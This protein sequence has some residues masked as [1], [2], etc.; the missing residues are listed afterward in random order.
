[1]IQANNIIK[2][3]GDNT[4]LKG[5]NMDI[6]DARL[7]MLCGRS[8]SGKTTLLNILCGLDLPTEGAIYYS[9]NNI[10][11]LPELDRERKR[12]MEMGFV[13]QSV[14]L[15]PSMSAYEN[16]EF[17]LR[18]TD[19]LED[20]EKRVTQ[21]LTL[22][23]LD[24]RMSHMPSQLSGGEQQRV[25]IARAIVHRPSIIYVDEP[26]GALD[27]KTGLTIVRLFKELIENMGLTVVMTTHDTGLMEMAD[28][29]YR[30]EDGV[31]LETVIRERENEEVET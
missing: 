21:A 6:P 1:M 23:G 11:E 5:I 4:V 10:C 28:V 31:I 3:F 18:I 19:D 13:F 20:A 25:A 9:G 2:K 24:G 7:V 8:G 26:T 27:T 15:I 17:A 12:R 29:L 22:V 30:I 16:V 14:A